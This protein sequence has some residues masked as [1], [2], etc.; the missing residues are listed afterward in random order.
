MPI[1]TIQLFKGRSPEVKRDLVK[2]VTEAVAG[3]ADLLPETV[4]VLIE[5]YERDSWAVGG[6]LFSDK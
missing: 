5:E 1:V 3:A 4:T 2:R 6:T